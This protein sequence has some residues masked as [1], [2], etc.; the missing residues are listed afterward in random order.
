MLQLQPAWSFG[1]K[2]ICVLTSGREIG[3]RCQANIP[4]FREI[5]L[6]LAAHNLGHLDLEFARMFLPRAE[7][8]MLVLVAVA[9]IPG[10]LG[11]PPAINAVVQTI[12]PGIAKRKL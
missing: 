2:L 9:V 11:R 7:D 6:Q 3:G 10:I 5:A 4:T 1:S 8:L 12:S